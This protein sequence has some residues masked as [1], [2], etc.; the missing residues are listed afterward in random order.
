MEPARPAYADTLEQLLAHLERTGRS[1]RAVVWAHN[2]HVGDARATEMGARGELNIG[3]LMRERHGR[4]TLNLGFTTYTG[5]VTAASQWDAAAERKRVRSALLDSYEA[6]FHATHM[7]AFL[8]C[9]LPAG[10]SGRALREPRPHRARQLSP[11]DLLAR[12]RNRP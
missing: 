2:S 3:Q 8:L 10:D 6:V 7:S 9:P 1:A 4:D 12:G 11:T 5:T